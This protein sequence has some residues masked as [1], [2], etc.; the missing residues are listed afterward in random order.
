[1]AKLY[2]HKIDIA[3]QQ[4]TSVNWLKYCL[5]KANNEQV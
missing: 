3:V 1:M 4:E 5:K 2:L